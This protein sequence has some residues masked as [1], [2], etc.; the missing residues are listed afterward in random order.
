MGK[1]DILQ[2]LFCRTATVSYCQTHGERIFFVFNENKSNVFLNKVGYCT[3]IGTH[4]PLLLNF[5]ALEI[6]AF[7]AMYLYLCFIMNQ[8]ETIAKYNNLFVW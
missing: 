8:N 7:L 2:R 4:F 6:F 5:G 1:G 3:L